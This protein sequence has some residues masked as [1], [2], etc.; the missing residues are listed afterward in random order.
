MFLVFIFQSHRFSTLAGKRKGRTSQP[1][2]YVGVGCLL[3]TWSKNVNSLNYSWIF[4]QLALSL[5]LDIIRYIVY[6]SKRRIR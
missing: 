1:H 3:H 5:H 4:P 6:V 2:R